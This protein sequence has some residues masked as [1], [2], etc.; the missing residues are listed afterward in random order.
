[1]EVKLRTL[2]FI[3]LLVAV[4]VTCLSLVFSSVAF[5]QGL[6]DVGDARR[7]SITAHCRRTPV[8]NA[9]CPRNGGNIEWRW[10]TATPPTLTIR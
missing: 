7:M 9:A 3:L 8:G 4:A 6:P 5:G 10:A 1:V 2:G